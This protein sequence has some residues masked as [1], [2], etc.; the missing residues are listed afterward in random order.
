M[1]STM[2]T[3]HTFDGQQIATNATNLSTHFVQQLT[4]LLDIRF[5]SGIV[6]S[7]S[8]FGKY[9]RHHNIRR[10]GHRSLVKQHVTSLQT[11]RT[12]FINIAALNVLKT[13]TQ[14]LETKKMGIQTATAYL[15]TTWLR[16]RCC[17]KTRQKR[18]YRQHTATQR[19][20]LLN[21]LI[22][23]KIVQIQTVTLESIIV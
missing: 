14:R 6:D 23:L 20:A 17:M 18:A 5:T 21:K 8:A 15:V 13:S 4:Q 9:C 11:L 3:L 12:Y 22:T 1:L 2:Q 10:T 7:R 16:Y 19:G